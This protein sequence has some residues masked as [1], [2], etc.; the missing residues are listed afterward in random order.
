MSHSAFITFSIISCRRFSPFNIMSHS[1][2]FILILMSLHRF[3]PFDNL[4]FQC[5]LPFNVFSVNVLSHS[6]FCPSTFFTVGIFYFNI[7]S[8]NHVN[9]QFHH[10]LTLFL[11]SEWLQKATK[12]IFRMV[13]LKKNI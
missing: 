4:F 6:T 5:F 12:N 13:W 11:S 7:L 1:A 8:V 3:D 10:F 2:F 9:C